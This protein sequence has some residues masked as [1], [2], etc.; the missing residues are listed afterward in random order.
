MF[1]SRMLNEHSTSLQE[2]RLL[3]QRIPIHPEKPALASTAAQIH[4]R[5]MQELR[6][7]SG[8]DFDRAYLKYQIKMHEQAIDLLKGADRSVEHSQLHQHLQQTEPDLVKHLF[9]ARNLE[10][11]LVAQY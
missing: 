4:Q 5:T 3:A 10:R 11:Q 8:R 9:A 6:A 1:A 7:L 2:G